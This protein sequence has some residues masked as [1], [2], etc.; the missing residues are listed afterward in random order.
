MAYETRGSS[1]FKKVQAFKRENA[2]TEHSMLQL[3][4]LYC[5][6]NEIDPQEF[7]EELKRDKNFR[8]MFKADL[9]FHHEAKFTGTKKNSVAE[10]V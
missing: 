5:E 8:E 6:E 1:A 4:I 2:V 9:L 7:G 10:W 3:I